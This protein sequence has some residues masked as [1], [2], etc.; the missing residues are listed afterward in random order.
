MNERILDFRFAIC[1]LGSKHSNYIHG[2]K[3]REQ[4][5]LSDLNGLL[6]QPCL[7]ELALAGSESVLDVG[8]GVGQFARDMAR[9]VRPRGRVVGI[10]RDAK[11]L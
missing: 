6:N 7:G 3:P 1:D 8:S 2:S 9:V 5:R 11:Q 4:R 10:E